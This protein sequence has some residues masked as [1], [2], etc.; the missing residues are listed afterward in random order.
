MHSVCGESN[1]QIAWLFFFPFPFFLKFGHSCT[2]RDGV[3][4]SLKTLTAAESK[5]FKIQYRALFQTG[6][7]KKEG[8]GNEHHPVKC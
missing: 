3:I 6:N 4:Y 2:S 5:I 7:A 8:V 1:K